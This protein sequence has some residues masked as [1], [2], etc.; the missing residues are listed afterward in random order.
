MKV[1]VYDNPFRIFIGEDDKKHDGTWLSVTKV[2]DK[3][4]LEVDNGTRIVN[5]FDHLWEALDSLTGIV[6]TLEKEIE[7]KCNSS[8]ES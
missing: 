2:A 4:L 1:K 3:F 6:K 5:E 8:S 7:T